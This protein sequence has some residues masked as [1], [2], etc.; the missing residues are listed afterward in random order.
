MRR[1]PINLVGRRRK[2]LKDIAA[3][4]H[5]LKT[6]RGVLRDVIRDAVP[7]IA[8]LGTSGAKCQSCGSALDEPAGFCCES[9]AVHS[10]AEQG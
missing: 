9:P 7:A 4:E 2:L 1:R 10:P 5:D 6:A 8:M 3:V